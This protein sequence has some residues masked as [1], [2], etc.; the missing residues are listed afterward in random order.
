MHKPLSEGSR[1]DSG[2]SPMA[3]LMLL[4]VG[5]MWGL[6]FSFAKAASEAGIG[7][8]AYGFWQTTGA[9]SV[10]LVICGMRRES[11]RLD[12]R[13]LTYCLTCGALSLA[14]PNFILQMVI[15][16]VPAGVAAIIITT[17]PLLTYPM[18]M[19]AKLETFAAR[20]A[21]GLMLG[22]IGALVLVVPKAS[23]PEPAMAGWVGFGFLAA[24]F[25]ASGNVYVALRR[26]G[27]S[28]L[29]LAAGMLWGAAFW[30]APVVLL[31]HSFQPLTLPFSFG[32][33]GVIGQIT[34]TS[35]A[36]ILYFEI[37]RRAGPV[38]FSQVAYVVTLSA[39]LWAMVIFGERH[40]V[41]VWLAAALIAS[42]VALVNWRR[43]NP[44][45]GAA[46]RHSKARRGG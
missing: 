1:A 6:T 28:A 23:L 27:S 20:R 41:L 34:V 18:A 24:L 42:G 12:S 32:E 38:F 39:I 45:A 33:W 10:L 21:V 35:L 31:T 13:H 4:T 29:P 44:A 19:V 15:G 22:F 14:A 3:L 17:V 2:A 11:L 5:S 25:Y 16:H 7:P 8:L 26:P 30:Q 36:S 37:M 46:S 40:S 9:G 43:R